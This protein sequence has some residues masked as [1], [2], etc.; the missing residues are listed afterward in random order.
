MPVLY[1]I[2]AI[3]V[4]VALWIMGVF[5]KLT[6]LRMAVKN[7]FANIDVRLKK[8]YDLIPN[9]VAT[10]KEYMT[11]ERELLERITALRSQAMQPGLEPKEQMKV[12]NQL[13]SSLRQL[14]V[15]IENYPD[16]KANDNVLMLQ[17]SLS[18]I[19]QEIAMSRDMYNNLTGE[20]NT[21]IA[22][23]PNN[24]FAGMLGFQAESFLET[25]QE[26]R[27]NVSVGEL[28]KK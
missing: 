9:L 16:L 25:P 19:E 23:F 13:S 1:I 11:H 7:A 5:N 4:L 15:Q 24:L 2:I 3:V 6:R 12:E 27:A 21:Q 26:E 14:N 22:I 20:Y 8:R 10:V 28:F 18:Q 17:S